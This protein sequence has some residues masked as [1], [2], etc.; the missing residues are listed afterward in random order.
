VIFYLATAYLLGRE[1][2]ELAAMRYLPPSE[3]T[4]LR[5]RRQATVFV[6]GLFIA[7]FVAIPVI[8]LASPLFGM[9]FMVHVYKRIERKP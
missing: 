6:A 8:N 1:Y 7:G 5:R 9:A 4:L 3:A 2:F